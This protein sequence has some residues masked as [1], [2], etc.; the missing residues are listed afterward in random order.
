MSIYYS[1][2]WAICFISII[3]IIFMHK[4]SMQDVSRLIQGNR[5]L[6]GF[7]S[8]AGI[9][10]IFYILVFVFLGLPIALKVNMRMKDYYLWLILMVATSYLLMPYLV[11]ELI[12]SILW[13]NGDFIVTNKACTDNPFSNAP[14]HFKLNLLFIFF[15]FIGLLRNPLAFVYGFIWLLP[16]LLSPI[17]ICVLHKNN[18]IKILILYN[19]YKF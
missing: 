5:L 13:G 10:W 1:I 17:T 16:L 6:C 9:L 3:T 15:I 8:T 18:Y 11:I 4:S 14:S 7:G 19:I 2:V 12:K